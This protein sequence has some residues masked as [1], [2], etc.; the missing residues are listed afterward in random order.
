M[1]W[2]AQKGAKAVK[3]GAGQAPAVP[4]RAC[5]SGFHR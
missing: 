4:S 5:D 3:R 2:T 1:T